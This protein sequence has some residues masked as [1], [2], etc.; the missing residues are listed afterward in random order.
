MICKNCGT[1]NSKNA[2]KC[3]K[4]GAPL[5]SGRGT[6]ESVFEFSIYSGL[7]L[8]FSVIA[9]VFLFLPGFRS[10][11]TITEISLPQSTDEIDLDLIYEKQ[12]IENERWK[13]STNL[14]NLSGMDIYYKSKWNSEEAISVLETAKATKSESEAV[15]IEGRISKIKELT[16]LVR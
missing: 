5:S 4:C 13:I 1:K 15:E 3:I 7:M 8:A 2:G 9:L 6:K 16:E 11:S 14:N 12:S 10:I